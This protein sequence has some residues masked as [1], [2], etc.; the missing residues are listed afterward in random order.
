[1]LKDVKFIN[2]KGSESN[3]ISFFLYITTNH[4]SFFFIFVRH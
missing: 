2:E 3:F 1:M 4:V